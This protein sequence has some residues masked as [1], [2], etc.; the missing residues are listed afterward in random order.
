MTLMEAIDKM[1]I[2]TLRMILRAIVKEY[3]LIREQ[4]SKVVI[5]SK[6][7]EKK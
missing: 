1:D 7:K 3:P 6:A 4:L 2:N 5:E